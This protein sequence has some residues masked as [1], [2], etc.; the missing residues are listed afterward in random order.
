MNKKERQTKVNPQIHAKG[1]K[2]FA[3]RNK[4]AS[5]FLVLQSDKKIRG[6]NSQRTSAWMIFWRVSIDSGDAK[7]FDQIQSYEEGIL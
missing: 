3:Y 7:S 4:N 1:N 2:N 5:K 6:R